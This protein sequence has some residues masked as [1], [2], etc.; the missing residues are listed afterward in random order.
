[1]SESIETKGTTVQAENVS[2]SAFFC[3]FDDSRIRDKSLF[4]HI[5]SGT[6]HEHSYAE[7]FLCCDGEIAIRTEQEDIRIKPGELL[8]IPPGFRHVML[9]N[10]SR[11]VSVGFSY[12]QKR[13][14][15]KHDFYKQLEQLCNTNSPII[16][17]HDI[18][19]EAEKLINSSV[20]E[21][22]Q[23]MRLLELLLELAEKREYNN[24]SAWKYCSEKD[25]G[26]I[27]TLENLFAA[28]FMHELRAEDVAEKLHL[29][30]R[31]LNRII[32]K[33]YGLCFRDVL[34]KYRI[35]A[36]CKMLKESDLSAEAVGY[37]VGYNN[38]SA[39]YA[40]FKKTHGIT[41]IQFRNQKVL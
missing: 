3:R 29:S 4:N 1:M 32:H 30:K 12:S 36:A 14:E 2:L 10:E 28:S 17:K 26:R 11:G 6:V 22:L 35:Q 40:A 37:A 21:A 9:P 27:S 19:N 15:Y 8:M 34:T 16:L 25:I 39:F 24:E 38:K 20:C 23:V 13:N 5:I 41:P 7:L 33:R 31:Q 18:C